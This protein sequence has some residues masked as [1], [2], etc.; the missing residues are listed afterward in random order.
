V[1]RRCIVI[2]A[3]R[4]KRLGAHT[5]ELPKCM[6]DVA[7]RPILGW[8]WRALEAVG[9]DELVVIRGYHGGVLE[10]FVRDLVP[11]VRFVENPEWETNNVLLSLACA[12]EL[13]DQPTYVSYSDI[14]FTPEV[15][16]RCA[17]CAAEIGLVTDR[18][19]RRIYDGR[20][21]HPL[22][23]AEVADCHD[24]GAIARVG[25]RALDPAVAEGE[26]I[27]LMRLGEAG[28]A[29]VAAELDR[30]AARFAG[31]DGEPFQRAAR[32][33]NAYLT[34][35]LQELIGAGVR[36]DPIWIEG[37]WREIDTGQDLDR[38]RELLQSWT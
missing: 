2:A 14:V 36:V 25:K 28:V 21:E 19:F 1:I 7:G 35:L 34:D 9:V 4:G 5:D 3:G 17:R 8:V 31:R 22:S 30:L 18:E 13:L 24:D 33:R 32:Y 10:R 6:V 38:A 37:G 20:S 11:N 12:R 27:G 29:A 15:A 23:E 16:D 26:F